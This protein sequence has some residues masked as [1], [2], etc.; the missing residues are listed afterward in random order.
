MRLMLCKPVVEVWLV[1]F[2][3]A[4]MKQKSVYGFFVSD[5]DKNRGL[6]D[7]R[8]LLVLGGAIRSVCV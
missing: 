2:G 7:F 6:F 4:L 8:M 5:D 1:A 3:L